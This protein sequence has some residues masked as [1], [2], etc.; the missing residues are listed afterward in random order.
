MFNAVG[1]ASLFMIG[2][3]VTIFGDSTDLVYYAMRNL[4]L[5]SM[6]SYML[7]TLFKD[8]V[9]SLDTWHRV[10]MHHERYVS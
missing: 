4:A 8:L 6:M 1:V 5:F 7:I 3:R 2:F 10:P 9:I